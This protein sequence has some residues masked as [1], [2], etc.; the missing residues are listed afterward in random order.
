MCWSGGKLECVSWIGDGLSFCAGGWVW[1]VR[2]G[3]RV[4]PRRRSSRPPALGVGI[5]Y[6]ELSIVVGGV[7]CGCVDREDVSIEGEFDGVVRVWET[8]GC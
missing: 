4:W 2:F 8:G 6:C 7:G 5:G 3:E 1:K